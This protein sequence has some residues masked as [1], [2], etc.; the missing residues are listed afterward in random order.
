M[1]NGKADV[2]SEGWSG[3]KTEHTR[4][5]QTGNSKQQTAKHHKPWREGMSHTKG[6]GERASEGAQ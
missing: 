4:K 1:A 2:E 5:P 3:R 6:I